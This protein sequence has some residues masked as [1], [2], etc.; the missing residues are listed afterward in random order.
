MK[1]DI[2]LAKGIHVVGEDYEYVMAVRKPN[3][4]TKIIKEVWFKGKV[5]KK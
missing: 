3:A 2:R 4:D 5:K 1:I